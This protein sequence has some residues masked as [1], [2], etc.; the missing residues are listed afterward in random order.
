MTKCP[1]KR[2][3]LW[4]KSGMKGQ[5][6]T[7]WPSKRHNLWNRSGCELS[8]DDQMSLKRT[9][10]WNRCGYEGSKMTKCPSRE[11]PCETEVV[12]DG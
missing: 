7:K 8:N 11:Q 3:K 4:N 10:L 9:T 6:I 2:P 5:M 12:A 1:S